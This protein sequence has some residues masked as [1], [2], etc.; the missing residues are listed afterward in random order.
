MRLVS[1]KTNVF[2][3]PFALILFLFPSC[4]KESLDELASEPTVPEVRSFPNVD[5]RLWPFFERFEEEAR[6]RGIRVDLVAARITGVIQ[7]LEGEHIAGQCSFFGGARP[8]RVTLDTEFWNR[9]NDL[10][11]EFIVFHELGHCFLNRGHREDAF[12][13]G[14]CISIMRSGTGDCIDNYNFASR[15][16]YIDELFTPDSVN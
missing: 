11:K 14:R 15:N 2:L 8:N 9:S 5:E 7:D 6:E 3:V 4:Q 13:N 1:K 16:R 10:F 12:N